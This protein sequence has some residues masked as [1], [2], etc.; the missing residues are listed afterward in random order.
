M[1]ALEYGGF[2]DEW[3]EVQSCLWGKGLAKGLFGVCV[4]VC[5]TRWGVRNPVTIALGRA[6]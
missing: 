4:C 6:A 3:K 1:I 2:G 5:E